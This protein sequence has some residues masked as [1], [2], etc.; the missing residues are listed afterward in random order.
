MYIFAITKT[1]NVERQLVFVCSN[2][3]NSLL[4]NNH[5]LRITTKSFGRD[6]CEIKRDSQANVSA[7]L[8]IRGFDKMDAERCN[9]QRNYSADS[10]RRLEPEH[11][12]REREPRCGGRY[13][14]LLA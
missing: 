10:R 1:S 5:T 4:F 9:L 13:I 3:I 6:V 11:T 14:H 7:M 12:T 8:D 2:L